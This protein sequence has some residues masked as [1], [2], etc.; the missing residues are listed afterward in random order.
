MRYPLGGAF[1]KDVLVR[2]T[3]LA[4]FHLL[5]ILIVAAVLLATCYTSS[6]AGPL[7]HSWIELG[8]SYSS[9]DPQVA[10]SPLSFPVHLYVA[11]IDRS[12]GF[13]VALHYELD[14]SFGLILRSGYGRG[15]V[16][17]PVRT[18]YLPEGVSH[19]N[20][21]DRLS[22]IPFA[23][24]FDFRLHRH[25]L[26]FVV[27]ACG[28][29][30]LIRHSIFFDDYAISDKQEAWGLN[31]SFGVEW[32]PTAKLLGG[33][34]FGY[35]FYE[36]ADFPGFFLDGNSYSFGLYIGVKPWAAPYKPMQLSDG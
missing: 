8:G 2:K 29:I 13:G 30:R 25:H 33:I 23:T 4:T 12:L 31:G 16:H 7:E 21:E 11:D 14:R 24:G 9:L 26:V 10:E 3:N 17:P 28:G 19:T 32:S 5:S 34:R 20:H 22:F 15:S 35:D 6:S 27:E 36:T 18:I 1:Y